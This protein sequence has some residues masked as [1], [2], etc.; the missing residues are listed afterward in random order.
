MRSQGDVSLLSDAGEGL[1][2]DS[3]DGLAW[4]TETAM[5]SGSRSWQILIEDAEFSDKRIEWTK[6]GR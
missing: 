1:C 6:L 2:S 5:D 3:A 4:A